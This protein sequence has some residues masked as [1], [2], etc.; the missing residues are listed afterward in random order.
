M[1]CGFQHHTHFLS[2]ATLRET[3]Q[4]TSSFGHITRGLRRQ[5]QC[6]LR[7]TPS[8]TRKPPIVLYRTRTLRLL[9]FPTQ[10]VVRTFGAPA[11]VSAAQNAQNDTAP[12]HGRGH[13]CDPSTARTELRG[14]PGTGLLYAQCTYTVSL[15]GGKPD[16]QVER[17]EP[18]LLVDAGQ[19]QRFKVKYTDTGF[20]WRGFLRLTLLYGQAK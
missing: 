2:G 6:A 3:E 19:Y 8:R 14:L 7:T 11:T 15:H 1:R 12:S 17:L 13:W 9:K 10:T 16:T 5:F 20:A 4:S 18:P